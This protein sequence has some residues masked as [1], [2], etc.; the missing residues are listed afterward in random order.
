MDLFKNFSKFLGSLH[1]AFFYYF[2]A[3]IN[4]FPT[5]F[6]VLSSVCSHI[7]FENGSRTAVLIT[8]KQSWKVSTQWCD[9]RAFFNF[10]SIKY[11]ATMIKFSQAETQCHETSI[12]WNCQHYFATI[13]S[14][15]TFLPGLFQSKKLINF[16]I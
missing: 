5:L 1:F 7:H 8:L 15:L 3:M 14:R 16:L 11:F 10:K 4:L 2:F 6:R 9:V 13:W 12:C